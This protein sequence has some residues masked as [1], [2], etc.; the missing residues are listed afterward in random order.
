MD[1]SNLLQSQQ[2]LIRQS[3]RCP[4][5]SS[6]VSEIFSENVLHCFFYASSADLPRRSLRWILIRS[7]HM[8]SGKWLDNPL[9]L[10]IA[11]GDDA[12]RRKL[13]RRWS[14]KDARHYNGVMIC[15][16]LMY[17]PISLMEVW[18]EL[19]RD[20]VGNIWSGF[21][22]CAVCCVSETE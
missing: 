20:E 4:S 3:K 16:Y 22:L 21:N 19:R 15:A 18:R 12:E 6:K 5:V 14:R 8:W 11:V 17:S 2:Y 9:Q 13:V 10:R 7:I 1:V